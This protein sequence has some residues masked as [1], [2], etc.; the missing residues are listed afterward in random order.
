MELLSLG[1]GMKRWRVLH[2]LGDCAALL[3]VVNAVY[4]PSQGPGAQLG[5]FTIAVRLS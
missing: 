3:G 1:R 5:V 4:A 2:E